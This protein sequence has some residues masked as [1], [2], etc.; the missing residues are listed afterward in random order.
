[1]TTRNQI[2]ETAPKEQEKLLTLK[3]AAEAMGI[4]YRPLLDAANAG[5]VPCYRLGQSRRMVFVS[6]V[7][8]SMHFKHQA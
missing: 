8:A 2:T 1:M 4:P 6:E 7:L 5:Q 3:Q